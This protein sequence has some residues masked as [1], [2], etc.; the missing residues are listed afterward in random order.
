MLDGNIPAAYFYEYTNLYKKWN[1][2]LKKESEYYKESI[3]TLKE[4]INIFQNERRSIFIK[5]LPWSSV[6]MIFI[7]CTFVLSF[8]VLAPCGSSL[9]YA[10]FRM[11]KSCQ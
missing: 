4:A 11:E 8:Q 3:T 5:L 9:Q 1:N 7:F 6:I 2:E 10:D